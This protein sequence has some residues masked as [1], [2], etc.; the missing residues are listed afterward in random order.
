MDAQLTQKPEFVNQK[1]TFWLAFAALL[2]IQSLPFPV[3]QTPALLD[4]PN[5][6]ARIFI[7]NSWSQ[8]GFLQQYYQ[9]NWNVL[10]NLA[11]DGLGL[12]LNQVLPIQLAG[13]VTL[14]VAVALLAT[15][16]VAVRGSGEQANGKPM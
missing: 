11:F 16:M 13:Q 4:Y 6:L 7:L 15:G 5:H 9:P 8:G 14:L 2:L 3:T 10:P 1:A 12:L